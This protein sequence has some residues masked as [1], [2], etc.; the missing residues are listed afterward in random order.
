VQTPAPGAKP[1]SR[2]LAGV[3]LFAGLSRQERDALAERAVEKRYRAGELLFVE[4]DPCPGIYVLIEGRVKIYKTSPSGREIMLAIEEA[5]STV[6]EVPL[7]DDGP[8]PASVMALDDVT[9]WLIHKDDFRQVCRQNPDLALKVLAVV[10]RRLRG[11]VALVESVA[12]GAVR[13]RLARALLDFANQAGADSFRLPVTQ[14]ELALR[15]GT[16]REVIS[17][18]L[19]RFQAEGLLE[20]DRR[21]LRLLDR[22]GLERE[23][24]TE[25]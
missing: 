16:V 15:L 22:A 23:A 7:F 4:G 10:G 9:A 6:A 14:E 12:F 21:R 24:E 20:L 11:L 2:L 17:R 18:N 1:K 8:F 13:Q 25:I 3:A 19:N 5:P